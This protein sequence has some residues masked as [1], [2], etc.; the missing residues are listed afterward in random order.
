[1]EAGRVRSWRSAFRRIETI[2]AAVAVWIGAHASAVSGADGPSAELVRRVQARFDATSDF[3]AD[4][5]QELQVASAGRTLRAHGTVAFK[6]PGKMR[7]ALQNDEPQV[8]V[9]DGTTLWFYQPAEKQVLKAPF[10]AAFRSSTPVSFL[11]GVG[12]IEDDFDASVESRNEREIRLL[13]VPKK[14]EGEIGR[15]ELTVDAAT[16]DITAAEV[17]DPLGNVTKLAFSNLRRNTGLDE[18]LFHFDAPA[19][20]DVVEAPIGD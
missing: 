4:V 7:W 9:A 13:L 17:H 3:T 10:R 18:S 1:M 11:T 16:S 14:S 20:V 5:D 8:I 6:R 19:G 15:L 12:R 2:A